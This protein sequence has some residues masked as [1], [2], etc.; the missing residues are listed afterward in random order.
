MKCYPCPEKG[1]QVLLRKAK[2]AGFEN[3]KSQGECGPS[4][5]F[6]RTHGLPLGPCLHAERDHRA[7][8]CRVRSIEHG[9]LLEQAT[10]E[11]IVRKNAFLAP[12]TVVLRA[13]RVDRASRCI[14]RESGRS[15]GACD[16]RAGEQIW[17]AKN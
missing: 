16:A 2:K 11:N 13:G 15:R 3:R 10:A 17:L 9:S 5:T 14:P 7:L 12:T 6:D 4:I 1:T 8:D